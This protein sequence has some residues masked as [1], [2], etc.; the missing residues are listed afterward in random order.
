[1]PTE[2]LMKPN[3]KTKCFYFDLTNTVRKNE[4]FLCCID[5]ETKNKI[6]SNT[7]F[8]VKLFETDAI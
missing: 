1:M 6:Y 8:F 7:I 2:V 4:K 5:V 3:C